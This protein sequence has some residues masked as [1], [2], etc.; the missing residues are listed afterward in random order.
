MRKLMTDL[1]GRNTEH[2]KLARTFVLAMEGSVAAAS[3]EGVG[4]GVSLTVARKTDSGGKHA[5]HRSIYVPKGRSTCAIKRLV[6]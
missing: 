2:K 4:L 5:A 3:A 6:I 1:K